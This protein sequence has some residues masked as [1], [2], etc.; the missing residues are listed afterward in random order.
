MVG[1][2]LELLVVCLWWC[3]RLSMSFMWCFFEWVVGRKGFWVV[4]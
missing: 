3:M 1:F 2:E 4:G